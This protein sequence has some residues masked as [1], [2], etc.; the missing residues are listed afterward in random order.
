MY[1]AFVNIYQNAICLFNILTVTQ[2]NNRKSI[3]RVSSVTDVA[4]NSLRKEIS[5]LMSINNENSLYLLLS[6]TQFSHA[7]PIISIINKCATSDL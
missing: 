4:L 5:C 1:F 6:W 3:V 7:V 2:R